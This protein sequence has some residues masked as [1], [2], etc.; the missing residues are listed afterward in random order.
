MTKLQHEVVVIYK[1]DEPLPYLLESLLDNAYFNWQDKENDLDRFRVF[2]SIG[3]SAEYLH[4]GL[5]AGLSPIAIFMDDLLTHLAEIRQLPRGTAPLSWLENSDDIRKLVHGP[6]WRIQH[7]FYS[8]FDPKFIQEQLSWPASEGLRN[9]I[10]IGF[11]HWLDNAIA[12]N[13]SLASLL[14]SVLLSET[15][16]LP[17]ETKFTFQV[18]GWFRFNFS[19]I[20]HNGK[21]ILD[22]SSA[23]Q[24][25][26]S[27]NVCV[28]P[29]RLALED[30]MTLRF[31]WC[32]GVRTTEAPRVSLVREMRQAASS[33]TENEGLIRSLSK[34]DFGG[35]SISLSLECED[36]ASENNCIF[37]LNDVGK[38]KGAIQ[39]VSD[40]AGKSV[41]FSIDEGELPLLVGKVTFPPVIKVN[42]FYAN[43][44]FIVLSKARSI[45]LKS[46]LTLRMY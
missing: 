39:S 12:S 6:H 36:D 3:E 18:N 38:K 29:S 1:G 15:T 37:A 24:I 8:H 11:L 35:F 16:V 23:L 9:Q 40:Y 30:S 32:Y 45:D 31:L 21:H 17:E 22:V 13:H 10:S 5:S 46:Q 26:C 25:C 7:S 41:V 2:E 43:G 28:G 44:F 19:V 20:N 42:S 34:I 27:Q 33:K 14:N 4:R